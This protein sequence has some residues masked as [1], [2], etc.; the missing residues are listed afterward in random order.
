[1]KT[2]LP[3]LILLATAVPAVAQPTPKPVHI[4]RLSEFISKSPGPYRKVADGVWETS[5]QGKNLTRVVVRI[6][7]A[8]DGVFFIVS[9]FPRNALLLD[10]A[11]LLK[12]V[13]F[14]ASYDYVKL[15]L[16]K[17][18]LDLRIDT[19]A[20]LLDLATFTSLEN[21]AALAADAAYALIKPSAP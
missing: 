19:H 2:I 15:V 21:Q 13:E 12:L 6:A 5:Y 14:N 17:T 11:L 1:M 9:L 10:Q 16:E 20:N 3:I 8:G 4:A 18:S 7:T